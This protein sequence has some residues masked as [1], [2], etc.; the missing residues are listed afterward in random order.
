VAQSAIRSWLPVRRTPDPLAHIPG[1]YGTPVVGNTLR[2]LRDSQRT[3]HEMYRR[4]GPVFRT[5]F[6]FRR[7]VVLVGPEAAKRVLTDKDGIFSNHG[8]WEFALEHLFPRGLM[9][10][11]FDDHRYHRRIMLA[12]FTRQALSSYLERM[13]PMLDS[14]LE[15]WGKS[16]EIRFYPAVK[17][18]LLNAAASVFLG[19]ELGSETQ[20]VNRAIT[21][22]VV[23]SSSVFRVPVPGTPFGRGTRGREFLE[24]YVLALIPARRDGTRTDLLSQLCR[25]RSESGEMFTDREVVDHI[26][27]LM[28][29][30]HDTSASALTTMAFHLARHSEWQ[31]RIRDEGAALGVRWLDLDQARG[32]E[33]SDWVLKESLRLCPPVPILPRRATAPFEFGGYTIP[34]GT[35]ISLDPTFN[36]RLPALWSNPDQFDPLRFSP[37]RAEHKKHT[38]SWI[39]Y[40]AGAHVCIG[41]QFSQTQIHALVHQLLQRYRL[42]VAD[43][44]QLK[45]RMIPIP[46]PKDNLPLTL[47]RIT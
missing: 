2:S 9:L 32:Y 17:R 19:I 4:Y 13:N 40:G 10:R 36:H 20:R 27:F 29:A 5:E 31:D 12:A 15:L 18:L 37:Q 34:A 33:T 22:A 42:G 16:R 35:I 28:V 38:F 46:R 14:E 41:M 45:Y 21:D 24:K 47:R 7:M 43:D 11:D 26:L 39:P 6:L 30:A 8:G 1:D 44:Y 25:A 23:A 3:M